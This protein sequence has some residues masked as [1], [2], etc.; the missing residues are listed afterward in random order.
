[1]RVLCISDEW[2]PVWG[3]K[4]EL[5]PEFGEVYA[6]SGEEEAFGMKFYSL[7]EFGQEDFFDKN[8]FIPI[9]ETDRA[10]DQVNEVLL[11]TH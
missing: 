9:D 11:T 7:A 10:I 6:V 1:M 4:S 2:G 3:R 5:Y 8:F